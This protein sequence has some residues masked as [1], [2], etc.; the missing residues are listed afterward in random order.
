MVG[1]TARAEQVTARVQA[2]TAGGRQIC[3]SL[4]LEPCSLTAEAPP[5]AG[6]CCNLR[7][8]GCR[9]A[10]WPGM[11]LSILLLSLFHGGRQRFERRERRRQ[12]LTREQTWSSWSFM[13]TRHLALSSSSLLMIPCML[14]IVSSAFAF[15]KRTRA[16]SDVLTVRQSSLC[17]CYLRRPISQRSRMAPG[18]PLVLFRSH[19]F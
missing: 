19:A 16:T 13:A 6:S 12:V 1:E 15:S 2:G 11:F 9:V 17:V 18:V 4:H 8:S 7:I 14:F 10:P 5:E 3:C